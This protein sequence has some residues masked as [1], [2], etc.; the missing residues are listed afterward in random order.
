M[1][2]QLAGE[3]DGIDVVRRLRDTEARG[4]VE[5]PNGPA[6]VVFLTSNTDEATFAR[7]RPLQPRA[8]LG[9]P[10]RGRDLRHT[11]E[12]AIGT[13]PPPAVEEPEPEGE[14]VYRLRDRLFVK[15]KDRLQRILIAEIAYARADDYYCRVKTPQREY[16]VTR[17]LKKFADLLPAEEG[18]YRAHRSYVVNLNHVE[19]IDHAHVIVGGERIPVSKG[20]REGLMKAL[21]NV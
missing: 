21:L 4:E 15:H 2:V 20:A 17:T 7:A 13:P 8:F 6:A 14:E 12:L 19:E 10:F 18:F 5:T 11:I 9:K 3:M 1:D 16:L